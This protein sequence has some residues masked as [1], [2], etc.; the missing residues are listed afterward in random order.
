MAEAGQQAGAA[1]EWRRYGYLPFVAGLGYTVTQ[2]YAYALGP[3]IEPIQ[4]EFGWTRAWVM[5][6]MFAFIALG[7]ALGH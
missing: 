2:L 6:V 3:I 4:Q 1:A 7:S 5:S